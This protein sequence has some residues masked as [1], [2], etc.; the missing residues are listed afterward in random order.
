MS[1]T[2]K[3]KQNIVLFSFFLSFV[4]S[5]AATVA[6]I[7]LVWSEKQDNPSISQSVLPPLTVEPNRLDFQG[8]SEEKHEGI[9][10]L[11]NQSD[12]K[13]ALLFTKSS[14][15][16]S[17]AE[18]PGNTILPGEKLPMKCTLSTAG[19]ISDRAG[20]EIWITYRF[21]DSDEEDVP[22]MYVRIIL[23]AVVSSCQQDR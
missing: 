6:V 2:N 9:V 21:S 5:F 1:E 7:G 10:H 3:F 23:T 11:M 19:G 16:C 14:C 13:I 4:V 22:P 8:M 18:L 17:V 15:T 20:G 12:R